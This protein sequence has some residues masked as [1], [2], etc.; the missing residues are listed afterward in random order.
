MGEQTI[1]L[2][3]CLHCGGAAEIKHTPYVVH[4]PMAEKTLTD[5][6]KSSYIECTQ[7]GARSANV[8]VSN[9]YSSDQRAAELWNE[10]AVNA[11][12]ND[13]EAETDNG[14]DGD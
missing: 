13:G 6:F 8:E 3:P 7:C 10:T 14:G 2:N 5:I 9:A 11:G 12:G 1:T 4:F